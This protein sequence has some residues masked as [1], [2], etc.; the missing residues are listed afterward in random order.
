MLERTLFLCLINLV[1]TIKLME[2][3]YDLC[4]NSRS[5]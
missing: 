5:H 3:N 4:F 1:M 2:M